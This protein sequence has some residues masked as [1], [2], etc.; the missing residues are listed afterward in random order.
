M[1]SS[2]YYKPNERCLSFAMFKASHA[3]LTVKEVLLFSIQT[4]NPLQE[5]TILFA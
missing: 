5:F 3:S 2:K 4:D 1:T